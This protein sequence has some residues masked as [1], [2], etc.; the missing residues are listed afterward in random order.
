MS[1][2]TFHEL[3]LKLFGSRNDRLVRSYMQAARSAGD[4][5]ERVRGL[6][7]EQ[8]KLKTAAFKDAIASGTSPEQILPEAF[9]TVR[10]AARRM[11]NMRHFDVQL[12]GGNVLYE[13]KIAEMSTGEGKTLV[14]TLAAYLVH[15]TGRKV[16]VVTVNDY[17]AKRDSEWMGPVYRALGMTVGAIQ[18][19]MDT[20]GDER[21]QQY[22]CDIT[23][24]TNNEFGFDYLRDNMKTSLRSMAQG[25]LEFA[26]IDEVD[27]ILIDEARTPLIISGPAFDDVSRY[28]R[29][30]GVARQLMG[31]QSP[32]DRLKK[33][34]DAGERNIANTQGELA[35]AKRDKDTARIEKAQKTLDELQTKLEA[36]KA[37]LETLTQY[38]EVEE[39]RKA[40]HLTHEGI[41]AAQDIAGV[42]SFF[43]GSN[44]EWPHMLEQALRAHVTFE[45]EKDYV[46]MEGKVI[47]VDEFTGRLMHGRQ[48]SD[49]LHQAVEAK[50]NV[51][52]KEE[53]QTLATITLQNFFK[54][55]G[56]IAGMTGTAATEAQEFMN[57]YKLECVVIPTNRPCVRDDRE[58]M[59]YKTLRE[60]FNAIVD[61]I[62][63][64]SEAGRPVLV[65]TVSIEKSEA[66]SAALTKRH[67]LE[68]EVLNAKQ[69]AREA[70]IVEK[71]GQQHTSRTGQVRGNVT[72]ATNMAGRGTDIKLGDGVAQIGGL[73]ILGTE[74][75]ESRRIDNQLRGRAGRQGD[76]GSS[77][78]F[79]SFDDDLLRLFAPEWI[80]KMLSMPM[81]GW[82]EGEPI[83]HKR[84]SKGIEK[85]Q[86]KVEERNFEARKSLLEYDEVMD[87]QRRYFY[88]SRRQIIEGRELKQTIQEM[89]DNM[90]SGACK[91]ILARDYACRC[92]AEWA[93]SEFSVELDANRLMGMELEQIEELIRDAAKKN[94]TNEISVSLGEYLE[95]YEDPKTWQIDS[96]VKWAMSAFHVSLSAS[97]VRQM[98]A[99]EIEETLTDAACQQV[100]KKDTSR[101]ADFLKEDYAAR[102]FGQWI[103]AKFDIPFEPEKVQELSTEQIRKELT[104]LV[105]EK[106]SKRE[107]EYPV[108]FAMNMVYGPQ[109][110]NVY[111]FESLA[112][113]AN[114]KYES[115]LTP[116]QL[117]EMQP[118]DV[119][120]SLL[121]MSRQWNGGRLEQVIESKLRSKDAE[122]LAAWAKE[123]FEADLEPEQLKDRAAAK[124]QL[125][126]AGH[127]FLRR[128]L[129][130]LERY[131]LLQIYDSTWKDH[132]YGMDRL[133]ESIMLRAYAEKDPKIEYKREGHRMFNEMLE[134][135]DDRVTNII[136]RVRL[137]SGQRSRNVYQVSQAKHDDVNQFEATARQRAAA[138]APQGEVKVKQITLD[139]PKVGRNDPCPCG[140]GKKYK[141]CC[142]VNS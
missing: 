80:V 106:Y 40:V 118:R 88:G 99:D 35:E 138:Q 120:A 133:K 1:S 127:D 85:A 48:W 5:E 76:P 62:H 72:I 65:G 15:L 17:L 97:K 20:S 30:D 21:K 28:K 68:H 37:K 49:G 16:H 56:Q 122:G 32:Y 19:D 137:E 116:Q 92:I 100:D 125:T 25:P 50:E 136:F 121:E 61:E 60:K 24:G 27:S 74:R 36:D 42:G 84:I 112:Q 104:E 29:A 115:D 134:S 82:E 101:L 103:Q 119:H 126:Q 124:A 132:L 93:K 52:V 86:K 66:I 51:Q 53:T 10:E 141:K 113:W 131:V 130:D 142:G 67:G 4:L 46:V 44:M 70:V 114:R 98:P 34:I 23:Y 41:G 55:Y 31:L 38:Y 3:M 105:A 73:H 140:S 95:D 128:E 14:A 129:T 43:T 135:I 64:T 8:L 87:F 139:Q 90:I 18:S 71:A 117:A 111:A 9:A 107:I 54:L 123:R 77:E 6:T 102:A 94:V 47:I 75:H 110:P 58:D 33:E 79:L 89:I 83:Q 69:H 26:I 45:R 7:D 96:L 22:A 39:D 109:G 13:G 91:N 2:N 11:M 63:R 81:M 12:V 57:I 78:F 59:I 108:E